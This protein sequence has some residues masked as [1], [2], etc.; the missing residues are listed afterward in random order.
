MENVE[1]SRNAVN[2]PAPRVPKNKKAVDPITEFIERLNPAKSQRFIEEETT[3]KASTT[4][5]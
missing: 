5:S 3:V 4:A 2:K 1:V